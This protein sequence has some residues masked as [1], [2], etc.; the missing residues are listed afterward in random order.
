MLK[1]IKNTAL[2]MIDFQRDF[3][4][5]EGYAHKFAGNINWVKPILP[6]A[7]KLLD[8]AR[9][10]K[11][12]IIHTREGYKP[13]LSDCDKFRLARSKKAGAQIGSKGPMGRLL[14]K[15]EY[16]QDIIDLLKPIKGEV[17][18]DK[19][20][21]GAFA[22]TNIKNILNKNH[23]THLIVC[24][25]TADVCVLTTITE[26][27][28]LGFFC[29]YVKDAISTPDKT[30]REACE[31]MVEAEGGIWGQLTTVRKIVKN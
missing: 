18:L 21:Y 13:D 28:D 19:P 3:C 22:T 11:M 14:I 5:V 4:E 23:I 30:V 24:G 9:K 8:F 10:S 15:G 31:K 2:L 7:K 12:L 1:N 25:V 6:N 29:Y 26:A 16:G 20:S 27:T 17:I